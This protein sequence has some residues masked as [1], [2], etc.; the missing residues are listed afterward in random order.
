MELEEAKKV[1]MNLK[2]Y[3]ELD[4]VECDAIDTVI[5]ELVALQ[6]LLDEYREERNEYYADYQNYIEE[7]DHIPRID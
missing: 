3:A 1:L 6:N 7:G 5:S 2:V 4:K